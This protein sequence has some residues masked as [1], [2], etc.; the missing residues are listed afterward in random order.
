MSQSD[1]RRMIA[2]QTAYG[3]S[4]D[5][6]IESLGWRP[7]AWQSQVLQSRHKRKLINGSRQCGKSTIVSS[8]P[9]HTAKYYPKSLSIV[10]APTEAQAIEDILK[11]KDFIAGDKTYP[12]IKR[13]SQDEIALDNGSRILV[14]PATERSARGYSMPRTIVMDEASR[15]PD[16]VYKSGIRPMLTDNPE[17]ELFI[18]STPNGK[19]GFFYEAYT[20]SDRWERYEIRSPWQVDPA[21]AWSLDHY[22]EEDEYRRQM[23]ERGILAW[24]SPRHY[25]YEEQLE[26]LEAMGMQQYRQEYCCE[27]VEQDDMVFSYDDIE[28]AF[29]TAIA[30]FDV[31]DFEQAP[32][33]PIDLQAVNQ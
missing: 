14:I 27:F 10:L 22:L 3:L 26:N 28:R 23:E 24:Y 20:S 7:F 15:I 2:Q 29:S 17:A 13:D 19:Q 21:D 32:A 30:G 18:I 12:D 8:V 25:S 1:I 16:V 31:P 4:R 33:L 9:C 11:V 5:R 6:Y